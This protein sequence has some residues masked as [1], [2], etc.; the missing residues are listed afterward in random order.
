MPTSILSNRKN[1]TV[2]LILRPYGTIFIS[3]SCQ[4]FYLLMLRNH[5]WA[6]HCDLGLRNSE[7]K[8]WNSYV[9][10]YMAQSVE[11]FCRYFV[12]ILTMSKGINSL[13]NILFQTF[14]GGIELANDK[15]IIYYKK[16]KRS[17]CDIF[18]CILNFKREKSKFIFAVL[19]IYFLVIF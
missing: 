18:I 15:S 3:V 16:E 4:K 13:S 17:L 6:N 2:S 10:A 8:F 19:F 14:F 11:I 7:T 9:L 1:R 12:V 5:N